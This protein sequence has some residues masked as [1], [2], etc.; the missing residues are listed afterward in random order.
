MSFGLDAVVDTAITVA[1]PHHGSRVAWLGLGT[2]AG[3]CRPDSSVLRRMHAADRPGQTL[4]INYYSDRDLL[5][6]ASS[7]HVDFG[8][9]GADN[10]LVRNEDHMSILFSR[11]LARDIS[12]RLAAATGARRVRDSEVDGQSVV[13][14]PRSRQQL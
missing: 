13:L 2:A 1:T 5:V 8:D 14:L 3:Q 11:R 9:L 12:T 4:W 7:A 10:V 6:P